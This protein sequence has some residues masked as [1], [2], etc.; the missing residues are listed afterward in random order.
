MPLRDAFDSSL[1][2]VI[3][4]THL[5]RGEA[6]Q[7][8][9]SR[10]VGIQEPAADLLFTLSGG[11]H[12]ELVRLIRDAAEVSA[13][14]RADGQDVFPLDN[15][16]V[17][18]TANQVTALRRAVLA[19]SR[20]LDICQGMETLLAWAARRPAPSCSAP[21][22]AA[23]SQ[24][25]QTY[26]AGLQ[27]RN[28]EDFE[29][30]ESGSPDNRRTFAHLAAARQNFPLGPDYVLAASEDARKAWGLS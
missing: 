4:L 5:S 18:L 27:C 29:L 25:A 2:A 23:A 8:I 16:A 9:R 1:S 17:A 26:F 6:R 22:A 11:L 15:L 24:A 13:A 12:R 7:L 10:L 28:R 20:S 21:T 19:A 14:A 30:A 3:S